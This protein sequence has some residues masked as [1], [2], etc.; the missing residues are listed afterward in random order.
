MTDYPSHA[1]P[2]HMF[3][4]ASQLHDRYFEEV[5]GG[6][7]TARQFA[8]MLALAREGRSD[9]VTLTQI[10][11][12]DR[13]TVGDVV[14]RLVRNGMIATERDESDGRRSKLRLTKKGLDLIAELAPRIPEVTNRL[15]APLSEKDR[16]TL[17][18]LMTK[19]AVVDDP[20]FP[21]Y[22]AAMERILWEADERA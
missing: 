12:V 15:L 7:V 21:G 2:G 20:S 11:A 3:R 5:F 4:R 6:V 9:Q 10:I 19:V 17:V 16:R 22:R 8:L 18:E 1:T 14:S 13:S